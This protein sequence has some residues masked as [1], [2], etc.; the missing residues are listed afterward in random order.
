MRLYRRRFKNVARRK[1]WQ[2]GGK[3][4]GEENGIKTVS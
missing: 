2:R 4:K 3:R 1:R